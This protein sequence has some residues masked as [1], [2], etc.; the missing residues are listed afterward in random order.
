MT[1]V[2]DSTIE[3]RAPKKLP[4]GIKVIDVD[5]H[6]HETPAALIPYCE[7]PWR[8]SL[9]LISKAPERYLDIRNCLH[10]N[11]PLC[12]GSVSPPIESRAETGWQPTWVRE[13]EIII[14]PWHTMEFDITTG[15]CLAEP[16]SPHPYLQSHRRRFRDQGHDSVV[17]AL[18]VTLCNL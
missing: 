9:E 15:V 11:G 16:R 17:P 3:G 6:A 4:K 18:R 1:E 13:G 12:S 14:C 8:K 7:M 5:V 2:R 10:Q